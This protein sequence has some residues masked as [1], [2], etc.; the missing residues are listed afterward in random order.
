[1]EGG[2]PEDL[3]AS[4]LCPA[5][6]SAFATSRQPT[7]GAVQSLPKLPIDK[8]PVPIKPIH[9]PLGLPSESVIPALASLPPHLQAQLKLLSVQPQGQLVHIRQHLGLFGELTQNSLLTS[10]MPK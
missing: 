9:T 4:V 7:K 10:L 2:T 8:V 1:M 6:S 5:S 3:R